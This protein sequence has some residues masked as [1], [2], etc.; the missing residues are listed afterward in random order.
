ME[1]HWLRSM[2]WEVSVLCTICLEERVGNDEPCL[3][4]DKEK[5]CLHH[6]CV[7]YHPLKTF[8]WCVRANRYMPEDKLHP[9]VE[10][11]VNRSLGPSINMFCPFLMNLELRFRHFSFCGF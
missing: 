10:V 5:A 3:R 6:D 8:G 4:H 11:S 1:C 7:E 2:S 9:W